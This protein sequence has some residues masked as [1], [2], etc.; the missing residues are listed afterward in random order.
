MEAARAAEAE[1]QAAH[2]RGELDKAL[3]SRSWKITRPLRDVN[4]WLQHQT[5][6]WRTVFG[7]L[8]FDES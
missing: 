7:K 3:A 5:R 1:A 2:F 8:K 6:L 4:A